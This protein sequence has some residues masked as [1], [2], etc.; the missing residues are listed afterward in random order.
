MH[1]KFKQDFEQCNNLEQQNKAIQ[2]FGTK[3]KQFKC[4]GLKLSN[5]SVW[6]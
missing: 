3:I 1:R 2:I 5:P 6:N 4:L